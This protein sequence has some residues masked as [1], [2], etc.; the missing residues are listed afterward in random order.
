MKSEYLTNRLI[1]RILTP[2]A[3]REVLEF[4]KRNKELFERYEP[5]RPAN[6][7]TNA[8]QKAL[9]KCEYN[10]AQKLSTVRFYV[11]RREEPY[12]IIGTVCLHDIS[13][14]AY[15]CCELGYKFDAAWHHCGYAK[16]ALSEAIRIAFFELRLH[17]VFARVVPDN[18]PSIR[19]LTSLDFMEEGIE[20]ASIQIRGKWTDHLRFALIC[21]SISPEESYYYYSS[22]NRYQHPN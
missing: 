6:F 20:Y 8:Y 1:L 10:L 11:F 22:M 17:R 14:T 21:P 5:A 15:S 7:Y 3:M 9:L 4:Q 2:H 18:A 16:E 19:L 12:T 13:R